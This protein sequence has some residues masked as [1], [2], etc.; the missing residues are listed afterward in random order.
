M[1]DDENKDAETLNSDDYKKWKSEKINIEYLE[2]DVEAIDTTG[3][4]VVRRE[5]FAKSQC[6]AITIK[7]GKIYFNLI[8]IRKLGCEYIQPLLRADE[9]KLMI[10][11][12]DPDIKEA[13]QWCYTTGKGKLVKR[14]IGARMF[15]EKL[16]HDMNWPTIC[17]VKCLGTLIRCKDEKVFV[18]EFASTEMYSTQSEPDANNENR[19]VRKE[20]IQREMW[21]NYGKPV[22]EYESGLVK[23]LEDV[24]GNY[25]VF[26]KFTN[27]KRVEPLSEQDQVK[28]SEDGNN[29]G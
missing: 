24:P 10:R 20:Y 1:S 28:E 12:C 2:K 23:T 17:T 13:L 22:D 7:Y 9:K 27:T 14:D 29:D 4:Q 8:A 25:V 19:R 16:Y 3:Y 18:F 15:T 26:S 21:E 5:W 6:P 11:P